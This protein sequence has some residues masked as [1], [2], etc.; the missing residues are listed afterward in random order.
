M[1]TM[2]KD[3]QWSVIDGKL[4]RVIDF[5]PLCS[6]KDGKTLAPDKATPYASVTIECKKLPE[7]IRRKK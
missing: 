3:N 7:K 4:C 5:V 1:L 6:I 2:R